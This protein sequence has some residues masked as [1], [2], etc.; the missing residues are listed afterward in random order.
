ML[1]ELRKV[2]ISTSEGA[3]AVQA[4]PKVPE[5]PHLAVTMQNFGRFN[6]THVPTGNAVVSGF[7][8]AINAHVCM[9][10]L[11]L[12]FNELG[13]DLDC[14]KEQMSV[15]VKENLKPCDCLHGKTIPQYISE[16]SSMF[17]REFLGDC[18]DYD[19]YEEYET[20]LN[21]LKESS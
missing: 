16:F 8:R 6:V 14:N 18:D 3:I 10:C 13:V 11:Q 9:A 19:P 7:E 21:K 17:Y 1:S 5:I 20:L 12:A 15:Q 2:T 4:S